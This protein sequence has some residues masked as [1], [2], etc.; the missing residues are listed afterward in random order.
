MS[1]ALE[2]GFLTT[3]PSGKSLLMH[4]FKVIE[5]RITPPP[6]GFL[7]KEIYRHIN[8]RSQRDMYQIIVIAPGS[9]GGDLEDRIF[10]RMLYTCFV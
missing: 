9:G 5:S 3:E 10:N 6:Q 1:T 4:Y 2:G 7:S 8:E